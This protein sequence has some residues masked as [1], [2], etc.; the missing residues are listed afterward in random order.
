MSVAKKAEVFVKEY[1]KETRKIDLVRPN[2][3]ERGFDFRDKDSN[4]FVEVK[5]SSATQLGDVMFLMF[6]NAEY[7]KAKDG[8]RQGKSYEVHLVTGV[9]TGS[10]KHYVIPGK[11][12]VNRAKPEIS[13]ILP[14]N[15]KVIEN[16]F[17]IKKHA[18]K[19]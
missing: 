3:E 15:K 18:G 10:T 7:E 2:R 5:G 4:V 1:L 14:T 12:F 8:L 6:T 16:E 13:W 11:F 17:L 9:G 19:T